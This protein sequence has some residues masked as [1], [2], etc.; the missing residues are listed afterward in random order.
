M[1]RRDFVAAGLAL[2]GVPPS[3]LAAADTPAGPV[4]APK[5][6]VRVGMAQILV[7]A[8]AADENLARAEAAVARAKALDC[9]F[10]VLPE[11]LDLGWTNPAARQLATAI[12]GP[13]SD[14]LAEAARKHAI[15]VVAGLHERDGERLFNASVLFDDTG[16]LL[17][18]HHKINELDIAWDL[19]TRGDSLAVAPTRFGK[20]AISICADNAPASVSLGHAVG[21][22]GAR[23]LLSPCAWAVPA[24]YDPVKEPYGWNVWDDSYPDIARRHR[25]PVIGVSNVGAMEAGPWKGRLCIGSS[26]AVSGHGTVLARGPYGVDAEALV[27][28]D[29]PLAAAG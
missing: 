10:V 15:H 2:A 24:D 19:Y 22:L 14:R 7:K 8:S 13:F 16:R 9:D 17:H 11:C 12:P 28:V 4:P 21:H 1:T 18:K 26:L 6:G 25:M 23:M 27:T 20:V 5:T 29:L 3:R